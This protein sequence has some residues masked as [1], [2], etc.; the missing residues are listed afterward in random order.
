[1]TSS[2]VEY[3]SENDDYE[4]AYSSGEDN[5]N[6][7]NDDDDMNNNYAIA[8]DDQMDISTPKIM[9]ESKKQT[10]YN[11]NT[12]NPNAAPMNMSYRGMI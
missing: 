1:M 10:S 3:D 8:D 5:D 7:D 4:Y 2:G 11:N 6:E 9:N 12:D